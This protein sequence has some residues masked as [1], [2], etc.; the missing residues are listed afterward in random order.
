MPLRGSDCSPDDNCHFQPRGLAVSRN[1]KQLFVTSFFCLPAAGRPAGQ[2]PGPAGRRLPREHQHAV[3]ADQL[4]LQASAADRC[5]APGHRLHRSTRRGDSVPRPHLAWP[6]QMQSIVIRGSQAYLPNIAASPEGPQRFNDSTQ[7]FVNVIDGDQ[8][9]TPERRQP[10]Q[11][12]EPAPGRSHA[13]GGQEEALLR[14]P[15]GDR[16]HQSERER[17]RLRRL[18]GL[19]PA[20]QGQRAGNGTLSFTGG[21]TTT[22]YIDLND[23]ANPATSGDNA[24]KNP[25]GIVVNRQGTQGVGQQLRVAQRLGRR[26]QERPRHRGP[27]ASPSSRRPARRRRGRGRRGD[28]LRLA[29]QLHRPGDTATSERLSSEG[30]QSCSSCHFKGLT[31]SVVWSFGTGPRKSLPLNASFNPNDRNQ[32]KILNYSAVNDEVEDFDLNIRN[33]S[34]PGPLARP[35]RAAPRRDGDHEHVRPQP[36]PDHRRRRQRR[37][38]PCMINA[39][40]PWRTRT[41][42]R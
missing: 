21:P 34:G 40:P 1:S 14:Q 35:R 37:P 41:A 11:V 2:R 8:R 17:R 24:G 20:G 3:V 7:A 27:S 16:L 18:A 25:Q 6:N 26:P 19:R 31:D 42:S 15:L 22:R 32:Q 36:R 33:V 12:P 9:R 13:R 38:G 29:R 23:P 10:R 39:I 28:V 5:R 4:V 30:W